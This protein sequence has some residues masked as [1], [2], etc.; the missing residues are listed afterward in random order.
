MF[1]MS[2][3]GGA[4]SCGST[5]VTILDAPSA[6]DPYFK[7]TL[8]NELI[9]KAYHFEIQ[10][11]YLQL[12]CDKTESGIE[13]LFINHFCGGSGCADYG[14][15]GIIDVKSG[16]M[17]LEPDQPFKGNTQKAKEIMGKEIKNFSCTNEMDEICLHS[18]I[19][20][21]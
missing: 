10:K 20:L 11:D 16:A 13:V 4:L 6:K 21:G 2:S 8:K 17:L 19:E 18:K 12:R 3:F 14:N 7:V 15:F 5:A 9:N 1:S